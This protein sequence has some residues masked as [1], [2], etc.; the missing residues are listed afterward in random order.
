MPEF[1]PEKMSFFPEDEVDRRDHEF[2]DGHD[3]ERWREK[4]AKK[5]FLYPEKNIAQKRLRELVKSFEEYSTDNPDIA[6][7]TLYGSYVRGKANEISDIDGTIFV[8]NTTREVKESIKN[9]FATNFFKEIEYHQESADAKGLALIR[10]IGQDLKISK[11]HFLDGLQVLPINN[12][13][14]DSAMANS[15][16][17][18]NAVNYLSRMFNLSIGRGLDEYRNYFLSEMKKLSVKKADD[19]WNK[20]LRSLK[21]F[22][23]GRDFANDKK[24]VVID[25]E[26]YASFHPSYNPP[27]Q[28]GYPKNFQEA[29]KKY[30]TNITKNKEN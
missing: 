29:C 19:L 15:E 20:I 6:G 12:K 11:K 18:V 2:T 21:F 3:N 17:D 13:L 24:R 7:I 9:S 4:A 22:E 25:N 1:E 27:D 23:S 8:E 30:E 10:K 14:I 16:I 26:G 5:R 28:R